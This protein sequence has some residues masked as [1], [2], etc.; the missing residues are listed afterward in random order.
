MMGF[1]EMESVHR[2]KF[3]TKLLIG[4]FETKSGV[5]TIPV[6]RSSVSVQLL[7]KDVMGGDIYIS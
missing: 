5:L 6:G 1:M 2:G 4:T 3:Q 7:P